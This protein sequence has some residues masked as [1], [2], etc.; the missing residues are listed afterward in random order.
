M[1]N[2][3]NADSTLMKNGDLSSI[4][5][6]TS[7]I[8]YSLDSSYRRTIDHVSFY[9]TEDEGKFFLNSSK[10]QVFSYKIVEGGLRP[11]YMR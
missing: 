2:A 7:E 8:F 3:V 10:S 11:S 1:I 6:A 9:L 4:E 5:L